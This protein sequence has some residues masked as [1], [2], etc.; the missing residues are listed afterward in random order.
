MR[1][2]YLVDALDNGGLERQMTLLAR[3][4]PEPWEAWVWSMEA[5]PFEEYL[6]RSN[7]PVTVRERRFRFDFSVVGSLW[8]LL[9]RWR[10]DVVHSWSWISTLAAGPVCR[11]LSIP[12]V[13]GSIQTGVVQPE[14]FFLKRVGMLSSNLIVANCHAGLQAYRVGPAK[15]RVV[16]N[17]FDPSRLP[18]AEA[19]P[20]DDG[21]RFSVIMTGRMRPVKDYDVLFRAARLLAADCGD[22]RFIALGDGQERE[23]LMQEAQD[24]VEVGTLVFPTPTMEVIQ[25]VR[26]ADVGVLMTNEAFGRE[27]VSNSIMEYMACGLPV[28]CSDGGGSPELVREGVTGFLVSPGDANALAERLAYLRDHEDERRAMGAAGKERIAAR[29]STDEMVRNMLRVYA[30]A[31]NPRSR[32]FS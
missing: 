12:L 16:Y 20:P 25:T 30:D 21:A 26:R 1:V 4:L 7:V 13:D 5:G 24:L 8:G 14:Y 9:E 28:V 18:A 32:A 29:F 31:M 2:L 3:S 19:L 10:P 15:G 17:G 27:G 6:R 22:W 23:R 11:L